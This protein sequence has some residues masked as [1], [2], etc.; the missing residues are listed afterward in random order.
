M[1][2]SAKRGI[3]VFVRGG[4]KVAHAETKIPRFTRDDKQFFPNS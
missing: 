3:L 2:S 1:S 4:I